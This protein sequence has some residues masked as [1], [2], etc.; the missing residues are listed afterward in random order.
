VGIA[1]KEAESMSETSMTTYLPEIE[2]QV[3]DGD[4]DWEVIVTVQDEK[5][6]KQNLSVS[7]GMVSKAANKHYL[8]VGIVQ[9]DYKH[10]RVLIELPREA[11]SGV[12]RFWA[13]ITSFRKE[14]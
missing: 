8:S 12:T 14:T 6:R 5:D 13:P 2:C 10:Q 11:D 4:A 1:I 7:K 9:V 3:R